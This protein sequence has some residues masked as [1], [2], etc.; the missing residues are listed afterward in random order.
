MLLIYHAVSLNITA[1]RLVPGL[2]FYGIGIGFAG[3]QLTNVVMSEIPAESSGVASGANTT[4]RQVGAAL[5][6]AMIGSLLSVQ[7]LSHSVTRIRAAALPAALKVQALAGVHAQGAFYQPPASTS[8]HNTAI[9]QHA[10]R[11]SVA[12][13]TRAA[14]IFAASI[15]LLG[16]LVSFLIPRIAAPPKRGANE[17]EPLEPL[18]VDPNL[19]DGRL[20]D[21]IATL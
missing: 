9:L 8:A 1:L 17:L 5:G 19:V 12:G 13:G 20:V 16:A 14:L 4:V 7:I 11:T 15:V 18:D 3:A 21:H 2:A 10:L 6:V